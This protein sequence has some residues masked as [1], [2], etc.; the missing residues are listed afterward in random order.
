MDLSY[1]SLK[2]LS[3][4]GLVSKL[5]TPAESVKNVYLKYSAEERAALNA[6]AFSWFAPLAARRRAAEQTMRAA[7]GKV[8]EALAA[9]ADS[10]PTPPEPQGLLK[11]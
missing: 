5:R 2:A 9:A 4:V 6:P 10:L 1:Y 7:E 11:P 3:W 8:R